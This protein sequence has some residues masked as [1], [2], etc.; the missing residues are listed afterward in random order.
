MLLLFD[1]QEHCRA[2]LDASLQAQIRTLLISWVIVF[3]FRL[4]NEYN[5]M[6]ECSTKLSKQVSVQGHIRNAH[7]LVTWIL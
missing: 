2:S 6:L 4:F 3:Q 7:L 5:K 1:Y